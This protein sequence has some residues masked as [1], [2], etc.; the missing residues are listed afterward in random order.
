MAGTAMPADLEFY[1]SFR[2][3]YSYL[4]AM[5]I[6][7][8]ADRLGLNLVLRPV[9]PM[10]TRG[11]PVPSR[12]LQYIIKDVA[13]VARHDNVPFGPIRDPLGHGVE[14]CLAV[15]YLARSKGT[16]REFMLAAMRAIWCRAADL[17]RNSTLRQ[18]AAAA[19]LSAVEVAGA[20]ESANWRAQVEA[21][22]AALAVLGMWGVPGLCLR[23]P[24][25]KPV[26]VAWGQDRL[27]VIERAALG[28]DV[29]MPPPRLVQ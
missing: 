23:G 10:V 25:D 27:W 15:F 4:A 3:P 12:K 8:L 6:V 13:R 17:T 24:D 7:Q 9:L 2:S 26:T 29:A 20:V 18:V 1:F 21:N 16:E 11:I 14:R 19:G 5:R 28:L 22:A